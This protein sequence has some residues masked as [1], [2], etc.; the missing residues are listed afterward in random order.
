MGFLDWT[1]EANPLFDSNK[2]RAEKAAKAEERKRENLAAGA[3]MRRENLADI[4][5]YSVGNVST[6]GTSMPPTQARAIRYGITEQVSGTTFLD[7]SGKEVQV[8]VFLD[9]IH[10]LDATRLEDLQRRLYRGG[11][12]GATKPEDIAFGDVDAQTLG[13]ATSAAMQA[14][15]YSANGDVTFDDVLQ[16]AEDAN[17]DVL[18]GDGTKVQRTVNLSTEGDANAL[19]RSAMQNLLGRKPNAK[20]VRRFQRHLNTAERANPATRTTTG[21]GLT[22]DAF[23]DLS[24]DTEEVQ[25]GGFAEGDA[26][27]LAEEEIL[28]ENGVESNAFQMGQ[29]ATAFEKLMV[30]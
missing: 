22:G 29:F 8:G 3:A 2:E 16:R 17:G 4:G 1:N 13:A 28:K 11:F 27:L 18:A 10:Q 21:E 20:E 7:P 25:D 19:L 30:G 12:Y 9:Q 14:V 6:V 26:G 5:Q 24:V 15:R 23:A